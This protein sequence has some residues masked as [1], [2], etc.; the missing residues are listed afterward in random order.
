ML[1]T[2]PLTVEHL[3]RMNDHFDRMAIDYPDGFGVVALIHP[4]RLD[5]GGLD[6]ERLLEFMR[7]HGQRLL[8]LAVIHEQEGFVAAVIRTL[9]GAMN[10]VAPNSSTVRVF[11]NRRQAIAHALAVVDPSVMSRCARLPEV[12]ELLGDLEAGLISLA[13]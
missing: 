8:S 10:F 5:P 6:R 1:Y 11:S 12:V 13:V 3:A 2:G 9:A 7:K 4:T